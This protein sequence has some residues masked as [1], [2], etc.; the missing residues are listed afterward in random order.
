[1]S[2]FTVTVTDA[3]AA[4]MSRA[5]A[6]QEAIIFTKASVGKELNSGPYGAFEALK[7][8]VCDISASTPTVSENVISVGAL[9]TNK[10]DDGGYLSAFT[11]NEI[12]LY[13]KL[14]ESGAEMLVAYANAGDAGDG[15]SVPGDTLTE[16][17]YVFRIAHSSAAAL[18]LKAD[19]ITYTSKAYVDAEL[20][21]KS[22]KGHGHVQSDISGLEA[23]LRSKAPLS[24]THAQGEIVGLSTTLSTLQASLTSRTVTAT[25]TKAKWTGS[26]APYTQILTVNGMTATCN[27]IVGLADSATE[28]Q[29][30]AARRA[31]IVPVAQAANKVTLKADYAVPSVD[32]PVA[33]TI[34]EVK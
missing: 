14:G 22:D 17:T 9:F 2:I 28:E 16:F 13:A 10:T 26:A 8:P 34:L 19:H 23:A 21:K 18:T 27:A 33:V 7:D 25:A 3:G 15:I 31:G 1:M 30:T 11:L 12:G 24:H 4:L 29:R 32:L 20:N 5:L 6:S